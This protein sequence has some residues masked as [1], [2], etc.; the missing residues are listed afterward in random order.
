[1]KTNGSFINQRSSKNTPIKAYS[2]IQCFSY[3]DSS[4]KELLLKPVKL[5][6]DREIVE[7]TSSG[8]KFEFDSSEEAKSE[9]KAGTRIGLKDGDG[10]SSLRTSGSGFTGEELKNEDDNDHTIVV[11]NVQ[12]S[13]ILEKGVAIEKEDDWETV[14]DTEEES[15]IIENEEREPILF[16]E[17]RHEGL[18]MGP[19]EVKELGVS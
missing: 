10:T 1:M 2:P 3:I 11:E 13:I 7:S 9:A 15:I 14:V 19:E 18:P 8:G 12:E 16:K 5:D 4:G 6:L 17:R